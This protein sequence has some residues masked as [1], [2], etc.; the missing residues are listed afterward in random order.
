MWIPILLIGFTSCLENDI[1]Y[2]R[3]KAQILK[4]EAKGQISPAV[5]DN[6]AGMVILTLSDTVDLRHVT[7]TSAEITEEARASFR[8]DSVLNLS[9]P[10]KVILSIYQ[11]YPWTI[12]AKQS[13]ER[14]FEVEGQIGE[15]I[16]DEDNHKAIAFVGKDANLKQIKIKKLILGPSSITTIRPAIEMLQDF[17]NKKTVVVTYRDIME[18]WDLLVVRS[19]SDVSTNRVDAWTH[20]AWLSG[21]GLEGADNGFEYKESGESEWNKVPPAWMIETGSS[22]KARLINLKEKTTYVCRAF[23]NGQYG[24]E[25]SFTTEAAALLT[26]GSFDNW[27]KAG[28]SWNP[29]IEGAT[30][31][32][33]TGNDGAA[34]LG[35]SNTTPSDDIWNGKSTGKAASLATKF[36]GIGSIGKLAAGNMFIGEFVGVDGTNG[37]LALGRPFTHCPTRMKGHFK[38]TTKPINYAS[39]EFTSLKGHPDTCSIY[40]ALGDW[41]KPVEIRTKPSNQKLFDKNDSHIIA[42]AEMNCGENVSTYQDFTLE[43]DYRTTS[44][45]PKYIIIVASASKY[46][47]YFTGGSGSELI[48]DEFSLEYDY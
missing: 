20:V 1:P 42:Y 33:D 10:L 11:D 24:N 26:D 38:Y 45:K 31:F 15:S 48:I 4:L 27:H 32:W 25:I 43:L 8:L 9:K 12:I 5:I 44:R 30:S 39:S 40:I 28:K 17:T 2:P 23:S 19:S 22:F 36:V 34:T 29:W 37:I 7:I 16:I 6:E 21:T 13:I 41:D 47:D 46:G 14:A 35:E 18:T 3:I